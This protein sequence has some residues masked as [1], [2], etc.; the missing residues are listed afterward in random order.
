MSG[1][2]IFTLVILA[3]ALALAPGAS[4]FAEDGFY[5]G[6]GVGQATIEIDDSDIDFDQDDFGWK[7]FAGYRFM[8]YFGVEGGYVDFGEPDDSI[9][10]ID[11]EVDADGWDL[12]AVGFWPI[13]EKWDLFA[14]LGVIAWSADIKGSFQG[15]S[16]SEEEDG[17]DLAYGLGAGWNFSERFS[18]RGEWEYFDIDDT[19]E[20]YLL[21]LSAVYR[22]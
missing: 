4:A 22:F 5:A 1:G 21:S 2:R 20:V 7:A 19:D 9:L 15:E 10:G 12:F 8:P 14:K 17:A 11:V 6:V 13:G 3:I 16:V 18:V